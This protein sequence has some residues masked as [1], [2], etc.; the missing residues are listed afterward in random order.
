MTLRNKVFLGIIFFSFFQ[1]SIHAQN[2]DR[3][4]EE[5]KAESLLR[6]ERGAYPLGGL[7]IQ[8][9]RDAL[10]KVP[11]RNPD[12]WATGWSAIADKYVDQAKQA[13]DPEK[14]S[15]LY[16]KAWRLYYFAQWPAPTSPKKQIAYDNAIAAYLNYAKN[17]DPPLTVVKIPFEGKEIIG[18]LR[19][20]KKINGPVPLIFAFSGLDSRKE[21]VAD[22]Y[23][24]IL[25]YGV[26]IFVLDSPGTG[27]API[28]ASPTANRMF[29]AALD[30]ITQMPN[31]DK[32]RIIASGVSFGGYWAA[33]LAITEKD[34][35]LG[36]VAQSPPIDKTF[37]PQ[38]ISS[39]IYTKE[40]LFDYL[41]ATIFIY[42]G[43]R[44]K[45]DLLKFAPSMSLRAQGLLNK[46]TA[47]M[48][49]IGGANDTQVLLPELQILMSSGDVPKEFWINPSGGHLGRE[50]KGWTDPV[51]FSQVIIPWELRLLEQSGWKKNQPAD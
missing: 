8:D 2:R 24:E 41:P 20:P 38:F 27:Q 47:P 22:S 49:V 5:V 28:K 44:T 48:L 37:D 12:D 25:K 50:A 9:V 16:K 29:S 15:A 39:R 14:A 43:V 19:M 45:A 34:R 35:L 32:N 3:N 6:A 40:Y 1:L 13:T 46:P 7:N 42:E 51:I 11:T 23:G 26:A 36:S 18:Y 21:T 10:D 31:I 30:Y 33:K 17:F 4:I